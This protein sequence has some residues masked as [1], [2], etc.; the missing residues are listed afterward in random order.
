MLVHEM[1]KLTITV[2]SINPISNNSLRC[3]QTH[4]LGTHI[5]THKHCLRTVMNTQTQCIHIRVGYKASASCRKWGMRILT[6][7][8]R[9]DLRVRSLHV[10]STD[11]LI[12]FGDVTINLLDDTTEVLKHVFT[13]SLYN[14]IGF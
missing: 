13:N 6:L 3:T 7:Y 14:T 11:E 2:H 10:L 12:D 4:T 8:V 1:V 9:I 5:L